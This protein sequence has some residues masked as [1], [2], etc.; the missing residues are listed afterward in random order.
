MIWQ[1]NVPQ[2]QQ[3]QVPLTIMP[4]MAQN[5]PSPSSGSYTAQASSSGQGVSGAGVSSG[6]ASSTAQSTP[7]RFAMP[8][9]IQQK[10]SR[11]RQEQALRRSVEHARRHALAPS[12]STSSATSPKSEKD[13]YL[14]AKKVSKVRKREEKIKCHICTT[15]LSGDHEFD[16]HFKLVHQD[17]GWRW[18]VIDPFE[19]G[20]IPEHPVLFE[21]S[22]CKNCQSGKLYGINYNAAAHIRRVHF[23]NTPSIN[24]GSK[25]GSSGGAWP[26][27]RYLEYY[28]MKMVHVQVNDCSRARGKTPKEG[29]DYFRTGL[30]KA[31]PYREPC[32]KRQSSAPPSDYSTAEGQASHYNSFMMNT[33]GIGLSPSG[34]EQVGVTPYTAEIVTA[35]A[36]L[37]FH[38]QGNAFHLNEGSPCASHG[39]L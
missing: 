19:K 9:N 29:T 35:W 31:T 27:I 2:P 26:E 34:D 4:S 24:G 18:Q 8:A 13:D 28:Y 11:E 15:E 7:A 32:G 5:R 6:Q 1:A 3:P 37:A 10:K 38:P 14:R 23:K 30:E 17:E 12:P 36:D 22:Q 33:P 21:I 20:L 16:R 25:G 39:L